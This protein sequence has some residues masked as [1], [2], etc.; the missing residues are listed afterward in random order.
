MQ[1]IQVKDRTSPVP[2]MMTR[3]TECPNPKGLAKRE[4]LDTP[5]RGKLERVIP[6][7]K[8]RKQD[9][10][11]HHSLSAVYHHGVELAFILTL[12]VTSHPERSIEGG[13]LRASGSSP[14]LSD[15]RRADLDAD[16]A[17]SG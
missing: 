14:L 7:V 8:Q 12:P 17:T 4:S 13:L 6:S 5:P 3:S 10:T 16:L 15:A 1:N 11:C 2:D 9:S